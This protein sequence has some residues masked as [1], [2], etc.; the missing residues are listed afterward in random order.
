MA[1]V[2]LLIIIKYSICSNNF[3]ADTI[4]NNKAVRDILSSLKEHKSL[5]H[6][7]LSV[8]HKTSETLMYSLF[9][10][11]FLF[12]NNKIEKINN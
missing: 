2:L 9:V 11:L 5:K 10:C 7:G 6:I 3:C 8:N 4:P 12:N 1:R